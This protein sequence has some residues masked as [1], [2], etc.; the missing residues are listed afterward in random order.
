MAVCIE[1]CV[2]SI[3]ESIEKNGIKNIKKNFENGINRT[4]KREH[5]GD[6]GKRMNVCL[7]QNGRFFS[8]TVVVFHGVCVVTKMLLSFYASTILKEE[9]RNTGKKWGVELCYTN[10]L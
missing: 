6:C 3:I 8:I 9:V 5:A 1:K 4:I 7:I 10:G 2:L